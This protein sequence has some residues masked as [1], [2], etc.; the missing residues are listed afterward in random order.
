MAELSADIVE[1][2]YESA[3]VPEA[4]PRA[5]EELSEIVDGRGAALIVVGLSGRAAVL[6]SPSYRPIAETFF[7]KLAGK[8]ENPRPI[9]HLQRQHHGF[10]ADLDLSSEQELAT[11]PI[12]EVVL[13]PNGV[14][15][16]AG[17]TI[18][19]PHGDVLLFDV[20]R[21][22][23]AGP[24]GVTALAALDLHRPHLARAAL[25]SAR[26]GLER[27][28]CTADALEAL[29]LPGAVVTASGK[30]LATN[31]L[32][33]GLAPRV[34]TRA[35]DRLWIANPS[36]REPFAA[37]LSAI[38]DR[39]PGRSFPL[40]GDD[41]HAAA[42]LHLVPLKRS[43]LDIFSGAAAFIVATS[44][45][46]TIE[47]PASALAGLFDLSPAEAN[48]ARRIVEGLSVANTSVRLQLAPA[49]VRS[50]LKSIFA[51]T[52]V[53]RQSELVALLARASLPNKFDA[54][55]K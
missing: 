14:A 17:T 54:S 22:S 55:R 20:L 39:S 7:T 42:I 23:S 41:A 31:G 40:P 27:A 1:H 34:T 13:R 28:R 53:K 33:E 6:N 35:G 3:F 16:S 52:G 2:I 38:H 48:V 4:W 36:V 19:L 9:R 32:F 12:Y 25:V 49:T 51:K 5:L 10:L 15:H 21:A 44:L 29:G 37:A 45:A 18:A 24:F 30:A 50:H 47:I 11:D 43:A 26:L 46:S 8:F